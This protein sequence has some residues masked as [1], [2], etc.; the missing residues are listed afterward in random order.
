VRKFLT[1]ARTHILMVLLL[2]VAAACASPSPLDED[3]FDTILIEGASGKQVDCFV[4]INHGD[5][6]GFACVKK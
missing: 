2:F 4:L 6:E 5:I 3:D 1:D